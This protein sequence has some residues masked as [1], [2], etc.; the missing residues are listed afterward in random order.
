VGGAEKER[1]DWRADRRVLRSLSFRWRGQ[2]G[3]SAKGCTPTWVEGRESFPVPQCPLAPVT[4]R[5]SISRL[6][7]T[8]AA[9]DGR[10]R[11]W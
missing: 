2:A 1:E 6:K 11:L 9:A 10:L 8:A 7:N 5:D 3:S 4:S